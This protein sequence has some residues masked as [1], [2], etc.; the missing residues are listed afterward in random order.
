MPR[1]K[2]SRSCPNDRD[3]KMVYAS[4]LADLGQAEAGLATGEGT[5]ERYAG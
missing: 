2:P 1:V 5:A 3:M 4:Q